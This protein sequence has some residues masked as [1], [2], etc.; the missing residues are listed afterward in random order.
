MC[1]D[2]VVTDTLGRRER[3]KRATR[4]ALDAAAKELFAQRGYADTTVRDI[5]DAAGVTERTFFRYFAGKEELILD[6]VLAWLPLLQQAIIARPADEPPLVAVL[7]ATSALLRARAGRSDQSPLLLFAHGRPVG[8]VGAAGPAFMVRV[9][10]GLAEALRQRPGASAGLE[11]DLSA[12]VALAVFRT[13]MIEAT[14]NG[15]SPD[16]R[17]NDVAD[18]LDEALDMVRAVAG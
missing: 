7:R 16:S 4:E 14:R 2:D 10:E 8:R 13:V 1:K 12:R 15:H 9:E 6:D 5:A 17:R 11:S 3:N 18:R